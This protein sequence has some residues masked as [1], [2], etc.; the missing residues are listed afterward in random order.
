VPGFGFSVVPAPRILFL[1]NEPHD[2]DNRNTDTRHYGFFLRPARHLGS[3]SSTH[4]GPHGDT[5]RRPQNLYAR[6]T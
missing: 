1:M 5:N 3:Q 6:L 4:L 2:P